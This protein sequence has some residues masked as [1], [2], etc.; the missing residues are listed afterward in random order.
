MSM[1]VCT[2]QKV[3]NPDCGQ[4][5]FTESNGTGEYQTS[6]A[7]KQVS[8]SDNP[9]I[10][11]LE[12]SNGECTKHQV[13]VVCSQVESPLS[14]E[15]EKVPSLGVNPVRSPPKRLKNRHSRGHRKAVLFLKRGNKCRPSENGLINVLPSLLS[16]N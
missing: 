1:H 16:R 3:T 9:K 15:V 14:D 12:M 11:S 8:P 2:K 6:A 4:T 13:I 5:T 10:G 7:T